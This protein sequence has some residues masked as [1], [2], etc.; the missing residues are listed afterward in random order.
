M[1]SL[2]TLKGG[3]EPQRTW[4]KRLWYGERGSSTHQSP[5]TIRWYA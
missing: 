3:F 1:S 4:W 2:V 5:Q